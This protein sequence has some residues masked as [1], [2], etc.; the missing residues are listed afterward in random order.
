MEK[1]NICLLAIIIL[2]IVFFGIIIFINLF[3]EPADD[4][5]ITFREVRERCDKN[6]YK[7]GDVV[8]VRD[9]LSGVWYNE[10][11]NY[12][13]MTFE[14]MDDNRTALWGYDAGYPE[15]IT[16]EFKIGDRVRIKIEFED[17][18]EFDKDIIGRIKTIEH[19]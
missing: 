8:Y 3:T 10:S 7:L 17:G 12:T 5:Y 18:S 6:E 13:F 9:T 19:D 1:R 15:N 16:N 11:A 4:V 2:L 14:S